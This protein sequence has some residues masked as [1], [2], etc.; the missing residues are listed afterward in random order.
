MQG[1]DAG[2]DGGMLMEGAVER[3]REA[4]RYKGVTLRRKMIHSLLCSLSL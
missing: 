3:A 2:D 1:R 4:N